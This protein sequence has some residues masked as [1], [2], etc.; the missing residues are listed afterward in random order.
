MDTDAGWSIAIESVYRSESEVIAFRAIS[1]EGM[2][3][4]VISTVADSVTIPESGDLP[5]THFIIGKAWDWGDTETTHSLW[6]LMRSRP[7][8]KMSVSM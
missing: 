5:I 6:I 3:A 2:A 1:A 8:L 7:N 4:K